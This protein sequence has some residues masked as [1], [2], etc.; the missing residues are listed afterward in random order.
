LHVLNAV[1]GRTGTYN[2]I[3]KLRF[4]TTFRPIA[5]AILARDDR[6]KLTFEDIRDEIMFV[7]MF[8]SLGP[9]YVT[10][11]KQPIADALL[12]NAAVAGQI[13]SMLLSLWGHRYLIEQGYLDR[14]EAT[15]LYSSFLIPALARVRGGLGSTP[16]Q[17]STYVLNHLLEAGAISLGSDGHVKINSAVADADIVSAAVEFIS[18]MAKGD[19]AAIK[20]LLKHYVAVT[21]PIQDLLVRIGPA[22]EPQRLVYRTA[23]QLARH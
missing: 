10:G 20:T 8:D 18:P 6:A 17:G 2:N 11:T 16:S 21:P 12:E 5:D 15:T 3:L 1:G 9:Q 19:A 22:P 23:E 7:R 13:R 4:D 14:R